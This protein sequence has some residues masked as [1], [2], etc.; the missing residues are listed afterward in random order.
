MVLDLHIE[1]AGP[2]TLL[3]RDESRSTGRSTSGNTTYKTT[4]TSSTTRS[5]SR[6]V[7]KEF[8][9]EL[10]R[11][12]Q[13]D[14][15]PEIEVFHM[16]FEICRIKNRKRSIKQHIKYFNFLSEIQLDHPVHMTSE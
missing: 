11:E 12:V 1:G 2:I 16:L 9:I 13:L 5:L 15:S 14:V 10:N 3:V 7:A 4:T 6:H 8:I